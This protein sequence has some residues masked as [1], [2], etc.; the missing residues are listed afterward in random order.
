MMGRNT[1]DASNDDRFIELRVDYLTAKEEVPLVA[2]EFFANMGDPDQGIA[3]TY[4]E[5]IVDVGNRVR[6]LYCGVNDSADAIDITFS[7]RALRR[8]AKYIALYSALGVDK[9]VKV[10]LERVITNRAKPETANAILN[11]VETV[12]GTL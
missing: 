10:A 8:W 6:N 3:M 1:Q 11:T 9:P 5:N 2:G 7:T 12:F 4:A